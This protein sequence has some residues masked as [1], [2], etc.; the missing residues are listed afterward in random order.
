MAQTQRSM[1]LNRRERLER[2][3]ERER[4]REQ[5]VLETRWWP[6][7]GRSRVKSE[8]LKVELT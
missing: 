2:E 8:E 7:N 6:C 1:R 5:S 4:E 3:R